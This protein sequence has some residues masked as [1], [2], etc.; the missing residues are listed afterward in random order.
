[1]TYCIGELELQGKEPSNVVH[2]VFGRKTTVD[3]KARIVARRRRIGRSEGA[4]D[5]STLAADTSPSETDPGAG[6][7]VPAWDLA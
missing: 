4:C 3:G 6:Y 2:L 7:V 5:L 1:M